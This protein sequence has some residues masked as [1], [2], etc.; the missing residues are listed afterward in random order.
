MTRTGICRD[1]Q[2]EI[3]RRAALLGLGA[4]F[5]LG[6]ARR[7][8]GAGAGGGAGA[9]PLF[10]V[11]N[12][13][14]GLDGLSVVA[15]YGDPNLAA[16]RAQI[17][18]PPVGQ[19][20]GM[21]YLDGF[22]GL[23]P[24]M[25]NLH[26]MFAAKEA[27]MV[28]AVG[29][30][31]LTRSHFEG[32]DYLQSGAPRLLTTG[33]LDQV[34][35]MVAARG[36]ALPAGISMGQMT[37][38]LATGPT[39]AG[40]WGPAPFRQMSNPFATGLASLMQADP[41]L[42]PVYALAFAD[43]GVWNGLARGGMPQGLSALQNLAWMAGTA[44]ALPTGPTIATIATESVDTHTDQVDRLGTALADL[45]GA[46]LTLKTALGAAWANT[47]VMT[48]TE[49]GR[50]A[51]PN[52]DAKGGTDHGTAFCVLLAGGAVA[53]GQ[54]VADWPGL[55]AS[56]LY[57]GRDLAPTIDVRAIAMAILAQH[58]GIP[59]SAMPTVFPG[60]AVTP[61]GGLLH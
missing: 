57:E 36:G 4:S 33:W 46:L 7:A 58:V 44:M 29:N 38:L 27:L 24:A 26:A 11:L 50:T 20:G 23:H 51:A 9:N 32:Q 41:L 52:G 8:L 30:I 13:R 12:V 25:P 31:R 42:G 43:R 17:M 48:M 45:D 56:Q 16:L 18:A 55:G 35:G 53:G 21:L 59:L 54:V 37:P 5:T 47:V 39:L 15:P 6:R 22:F 3:G 2:L 1:G 10:V 49:F 40:S 61:L 28:H 34:M 19:P 60:N 14:G